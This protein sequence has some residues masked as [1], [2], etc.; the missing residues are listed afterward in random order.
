MCLNDNNTSRDDHSSTSGTLRNDHHQLAI[1]SDCVPSYEQESLFLT[2]KS[3]QLLRDRG[4][5]RKNSSAALHVSFAFAFVVAAVLLNGEQVYFWDNFTLDMHVTIDPE[6]WRAL[7]YPLFIIVTFDYFAEQRYFSAYLLLIIYYPFGFCLWSFLTTQSW[8]PREY[9]PTGLIWTIVSILTFVI[10]LNNH[11]FY[12]RWIKSKFF[13]D[14]IGAKFFWGIEQADGESWTMTY[15]KIFYERHTCQY[16]GRISQQTGL[17]D[18]FGEWIDDSPTG[19]SIIGNWKNGVPMAPFKSTVQ[20]NGDGF[21]AVALMYYHAT[22]DT[23]TENKSKPTNL[24]PARMGV[25]S[26]ECSVQGAFYRHVPEVRLFFDEQIT[27]KD[28]SMHDF[29]PVVSSNHISTVE[30]LKKCLPYL[31]TTDINSSDGDVKNTTITIK[32]NDPRGIQVEGHVNAITSNYYSTDVHEVVVQIVSK[33]KDF[34]N[35]ERMRARRG[36]T[37]MPISPARFSFY[38]GTHENDDERSVLSDVCE[39]DTTDVSVDGNNIMATTIATGTYSNKNNTDKHDMAKEKPI[40]DDI[41]TSKADTEEF[42]MHS[43]MAF[44]EN[45]VSSSEPEVDRNCHLEVQGW[46]PSQQKEALILL[47]GLGNSMKKSLKCFGQFIA[48]TKLSEHIYPIIFGWPTASVI[49]YRYA[50][51]AANDKRTV[52]HFLQLVEG[53]AASGIRRV[54]FLSHSMGGMSLIAALTNEDDGD[55]GHSRVS[56]CFHLCPGF[57]D[58]RE[59]KE[60]RMICKSII[61]LNPDYPLKAFVGRAFASMRRICDHITVVGDRNDHVLYYS[62]IVNGICNRWGHKNPVDLINGTPEQEEN[63]RRFRFE[64]RAGKELA[65]LV[66]PSNNNTSWKNPKLL[67]AQPSITSGVSIKLSKQWLDIDVIDTTNLDVNFDSVRHSAYNTNPS[68]V[69]DLED[70]IISGRRAKNRPSLLHREG[71]IYSYNHVPSF[72]T[73]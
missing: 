20:N 9:L 32:L 7:V 27:V 10:A 42:K 58:E 59:E 12:P 21:N 52:E 47:P 35:K 63:R 30:A 8:I 64:K 34:K 54:H 39:E 5:V 53:L 60:N 65:S 49:T 66:L 13:Q 55:K 62:S 3:R 40:P 37:S 56:N 51:S 48:M 25:A 71:N 22:D 33:G 72:V 4:G 2:M 11:Y 6:D 43:N 17:P 36:V 73:M 57:E 14:K 41:E 68:L 28:E 1:H 15:R 50:C 46:L 70:I 31:E 16:E 44:A 61:L 24:L 23:F 29:F 45:R 19:E 26:V 69:K 18:G 67:L 38:G